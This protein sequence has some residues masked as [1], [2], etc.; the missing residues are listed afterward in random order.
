MKILVTGGTVFVSKFVASYFVQKNYE[1]YVLNRNTKPQVDGVNLI[2]ADRNSLKDTLK[3]YSFDAVIDVCG[4][5]KKDIENLLNGLSPVEK[6]IF[7]SS[8]SVYPET[9]TQPFNESQ[10]IGK[11][12]IWGDYGFN[13]VQAEQYLLSR[14]PNSYILR[15]PYL[16]GTMQ[17]VYREP[18]IFDCAL[19]NRKFYIPK[20]GSMKLQFFHVKDLCKVIEIILEKNPKEHILNVGNNDIVDINTFV[21]MCY[22]VVGSKLEKVYINSYNNQRDYFSFYDYEYILDVSKQNQLLSNTI[23]LKDGLKQSF[24]WYI[25]HKDD[26]VKKDYIKFI[27]ENFI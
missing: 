1:V 21:E 11:N 5:N 9:N 24:E 26:V 12:S 27:D 22:Q 15:P 3:S 19:Q 18:F 6:Y 13:K 20:D 10:P 2:C 7:I 17:N 8:S 23:N 25:N 16:Y 14:Y 4:Y